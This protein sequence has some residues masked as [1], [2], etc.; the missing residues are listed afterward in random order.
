MARRI[1]VNLEGVT[2]VAELRDD[3][4]PRMAEAFWRSLPIERTLSP[5]KW[6]GLGC[7][8]QPDSEAMRAVTELEH[9]VCSIYPGTLV[10]RPGGSEILLSYGAA[11]FRWGIGTDY[12]TPVATIVENFAPFREALSKMHDEGNKQI[13]F[14]Q[15]A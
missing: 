11:E 3:L 10:A 6:S 1:E 8:L 9:P 5:M 12:T 15:A 7:F 2:A 14:R 13:A 4:S